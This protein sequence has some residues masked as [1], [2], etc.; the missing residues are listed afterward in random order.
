MVRQLNL[1]DQAFEIVLI[2]SLFEGGPLILE[3]MKAAIHK[4]A[5]LARYVRLNAPPV[6]GGVLLGMEVG[7]VNGYMVQERLLESTRKIV[8]RE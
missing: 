8:N 6:V 1:E 5:P 4:V 2:G 3:P 7:G